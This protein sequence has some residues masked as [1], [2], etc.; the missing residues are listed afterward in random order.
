MSLTIT[1]ISDTHTRH[2]LLTNDLP[3]GDIIIHAGDFMNSG[4]YKS[5]V[6]DFC[7]WFDSL[8]YDAK[9]FIAGNHDRLF[10]DSPKEAMEIVNSHKWIDYLQDSNIQYARGEYS[11]INI[12]GSPWQPEFYNWAFN[13]P[14][15]GEDLREKWS[16]IPIETDILVTHGPPYS[17][18][19][20]SGHGNIKCGCEL[21]LDRVMTVK[22]KIHIFG[23]VHGSY[24]YKFNGTTHFINAAVLNEQYKY[25]NKP[26]TFTW[27]ADINEIEFLTDF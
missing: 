10:E 21:L 18:L 4:Y 20:L 19:D 22:P 8:D 17:Y 1:A 12:W 6:Q 7:K 3:G 27:D 23:H 15:M 9:I 11:P 5:E 16:L 24:G 2:S 25:R 26:L 14:R 13:L